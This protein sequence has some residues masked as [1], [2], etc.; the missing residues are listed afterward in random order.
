[1]RPVLRVP[2]VARSSQPWAGIL[3]R[4]RRMGSRATDRTQ[5]DCRLD[6]F[7]GRAPP[8]KQIQLL[9]WNIITPSALDVP[10]VTDPDL[11]SQTRKVSALRRKSEAGSVPASPPFRKSIGPS[12]LLPSCF[13]DEAA[14]ET[15]VETAYEARHR[16]CHYRDR[17]LSR[18]HALACADWSP[19]EPSSEQE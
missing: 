5:G 18:A 16:F 3:K 2:R 14:F 4:L 15:I 7:D 6:R 17:N 11:V 1:L 19:K 9:G 8:P 10:F 13:Q 12:A